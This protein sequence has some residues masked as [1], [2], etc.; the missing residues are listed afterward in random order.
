[1]PPQRRGVVMIEYWK[2]L[3]GL[4]L[5]L[6][7]HGSAVMKGTIP[8]AMAAAF[9]Y[10]IFVFND[11]QPEEFFAHPYAIGVYVG[12]ITFTIVFRMNNAY[13]RVSVL[14]KTSA[15]HS[16]CPFLCLP[17]SIS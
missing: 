10:G 1:V 9:Y 5:L 7:G 4:Q 16:V 12:S 6:R 8:G 14:Q 13:G 2:G 11:R 15:Q 3:F 17:W